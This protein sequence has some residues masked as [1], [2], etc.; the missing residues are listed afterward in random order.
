M[1]QN[2]SVITNID[3]IKRSKTS[4]INRG[5]NKSE[6]SRDEIL[7]V[8]TTSFTDQT[9][10]KQTK[11]PKSIYFFYFEFKKLKSSFKNSKNNT[12]AFIFKETILT[13]FNN[14]NILIIILNGQ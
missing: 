3:Q 8:P 5:Y 1:D 10:I 11:R 14:C 13:R 12:N 6:G 9:Q 7:S 4:A 2:D